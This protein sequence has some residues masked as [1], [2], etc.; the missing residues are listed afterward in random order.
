MKNYPGAKG[1]S[2][3]L[4]QI[5]SLI[6]KCDVFIEAMA[7]S[8]VISN[9]L[10]SY[11]ATVVTNDIDACLPVANHLDYRYLVAKYDCDGS[12]K[13]VFY[14]DPPYLMS[15]RS[16][17]GKLYRYEWNEQDH[18]DFL[19]I[20]RAVKSDC[21]IS[22]YPCQLYDDA[23]QGWRKYSYTAMTRGGKR[24][25]CVYMN[26]AEPLE[27]LTCSAVGINRTDRQ[28]IKRKVARLIA[29]IEALPIQHQQ[30]IITAI[31]QKFH[32]NQ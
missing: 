11:V 25:E 6:P 19:T 9:Y 21:M 14:F 5:V 23:L 16:Y 32:Q 2:G 8:A 1:I 26:F 20:V 22:H 15:T 18:E 13:T 12:R 4:Q 30:G 28:Q 17:Q 24:I 3:H 7:G 31:Q 10:C 27:L 29:K